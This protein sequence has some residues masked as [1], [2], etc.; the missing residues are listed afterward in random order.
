[1]ID[2]LARTLDLD[3]AEIRRR[4][5]IRKEQFPYQSA[6]GSEYDS[7]DYLTAL[8]KALNAI[9]YAALREEQRRNREAFGRGETRK[10]M[11]IG[12]CFFT[13]IVGAGP[14]KNC[15]ILGLGMFDSCEIRVHPTGSAITR[16]GTSARVGG[17]PR[18]SP[19][20]WLT[21]SAFRRQASRSKRATPTPHLTG[22]APTARARRPSPV[23]R[24]R[25]PAAR[26]A[27]R[28]R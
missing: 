8:D 26:S 10:L 21:R 27:P 3:P 20:S 18:P 2:V 6:L 9:G 1:M 4:N 16:L 11:G 7:G 14:I 25:W 24:R 22:S 12:V 17:T 19:R 15:D 28:R 23:Q 5:L 13:E